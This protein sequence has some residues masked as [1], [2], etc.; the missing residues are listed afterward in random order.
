MYESGIRLP[1]VGDWLWL[2]VKHG[3]YFA[4]HKV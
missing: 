1:A 2:G 4:L 3:V